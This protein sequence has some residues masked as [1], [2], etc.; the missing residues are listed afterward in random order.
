MFCSY[1]LIS[2]LTVVADLSTLIPVFVKFGF[3]G[4]SVVVGDARFAF[5]FAGT[6]GGGL[7]NGKGGTL[8]SSF[9]GA[10]GI[11]STKS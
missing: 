9:G 6:A 2:T 3:F 8:E 1:V 5:G 10:G 11:N 4:G 7:D